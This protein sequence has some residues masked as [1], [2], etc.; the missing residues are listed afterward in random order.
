[1]K[2]LVDGRDE[3]KGAPMSCAMVYWGK[4]DDRFH[5]IFIRYGAV[6]DLRPLYEKQIGEYNRIVEPILLSEF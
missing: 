5:D 6:I 4:S 2:F 3:G 1:L